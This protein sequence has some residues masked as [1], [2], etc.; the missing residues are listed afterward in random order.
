MNSTFKP[1]IIANDDDD[2]DADKYEE[3]P[4]HDDDEQINLKTEALIAWK[5]ITVTVTEWSVPKVA[6]QQFSTSALPKSLVPWKRKTI[7]NQLTGHF[8]PGSLNGI[9]G[10]SGAGYAVS[11][12]KTFANLFLK[13]IF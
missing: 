13:L 9:L 3:I 7:L 4:I 10:P 12:K 6:V 2:D 11:E 8:M 5:D 1:I